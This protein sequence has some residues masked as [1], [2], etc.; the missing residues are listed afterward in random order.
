VDLWRDCY[1]CMKAFE[2]SS[3]NL[4]NR[5]NGQCPGTGSTDVRGSFDGSDGF[6]GSSV[7]RESEAG[8]SPPE[9]P[10]L[11]GSDP[12]PALTSPPRLPGQRCS[13]CPLPRNV[14]CGGAFDHSLCDRGPEFIKGLTSFQHSLAQC[15][16]RRAKLPEP[17][18]APERDGK[19]RV[20]LF[21]PVLKGGGAEEWQRL[22]FRSLDRERIAVVGLGITHERPSAI[23]ELVALEFRQSIPVH[24]GGPACRKLAGD[25]DV[26]LCWGIIDLGRILPLFGHGPKVIMV[27][28]TDTVTG[29]DVGV[30]GQARIDQ[31]VAVSRYAL[32]PIP[33]HRRASTRIIANAIDF[34]RLRPTRDAAE[35][36]RRLG[37]PEDVPVLGF[38]GRPDGAQKDPQA[39][40]RCLPHLPGWVALFVGEGAGFEP[41]WTQI[42]GMLGD[43]AIFA[44]HR[45]DLGNVF[46][47][48][49]RLMIPSRWESACLVAL[50]A[51]AY[52]IPTLMTPVGIAA[53]R[54]EFVAPIPMDDPGPGLAAA[55]LADC[56]DPGARGRAERA[57]GWALA[58]LGVERLGAEYSDL[59]CEVVG[60]DRGARAS[61]PPAPSLQLADCGDDVWV[62]DHV[63]CNAA[64]DKFD[65]SIHLWHDYHYPDGL[66][67]RNLAGPGPGLVIRYRD[68]EDLGTA[69]V[70]ID[71]VVS[72][73]SRPGKLL[74]HCGLGAFRGPTY[75][76]LAKIVRGCGVEKALADVLK[77]VGTYPKKVHPFNDREP[78]GTDAIRSIL[79]WEK[80]QGRS[81]AGPASIRSTSP[82]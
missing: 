15:P 76:V 21:G 54:P 78:G 17:P 79:A 68:G 59:I 34:E 52:G 11:L 19:V 45:R 63:A 82:A 4:E 62:G 75:A 58:N 49:A 55:V 48:M 71:E 10:S 40:A 24:V 35:E 27:S 50:E 47:V 73:V 37:I 67:A 20:G 70:P 26:A 51:V 12:P 38:V 1:G 46:Q 33:E 80:V 28:H 14:L 31:L 66:C 23:N 8:V 60:P 36:R 25:I 74:V 6:D 53:D 39:L 77:A 16:D 72:Y 69:S 64:I 9:P 30:H 22:V 65:L 57:K 18:K 44:G 42:A 43:R 61:R 29:W 13:A 41:V 2:E 32:A 81:V 3:T 7:L 56:H 5:L